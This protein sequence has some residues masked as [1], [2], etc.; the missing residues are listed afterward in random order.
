M[1]Y[2]GLKVGLRKLR[3]AVKILQMVEPRW[4]LS[5]LSITCRFMSQAKDPPLTAER[6]GVS[7][8]P[9]SEISDEDIRHFQKIIPGRVVTHEGDLKAHNID[10]L[11]TVRGRSKVLLKPRTTE[12]VSQILK[13]CNQR[14]LAVTPQGGN[15]S[16]VGGSIPVF[17]E[18]LIST[19]LM[20]QVISFDDISGALVC[21]AGC[22][23]ESLNQYL[24]ERG[25][26][27]PLDLGAK[28]SCH[29]GGNLATNAGGLR[30]LRYGS[31]RG[32]VLGLEAVL[33]DGSILDCLNSLRKDNTGYDLKQLFI[34]SEGTLGLI[35]ALSIL[36]PRKPSAVNVAL[37]GCEHFSR[38]L[39]V[40]TLCRDHLGEIL[41]ACEF[42]DS[43]SMR[44]VKT[45]LKLTNPLPDNAFYV[46]VE[47][48]GSCGKHDEEKLN[49]FLEKAMESGLVTSGTVATDQAKIMSLWALRER[50][51]EALAHDG[52]VYKYDL[53]MP[54]EKLYTLVE[55]TRARVGSSAQCVVGYGHLGDGN[56]HLNITAKSYSDALA[57]ALEPFVY[58]WTSQHRGSISAEHGLG[59][60]KRDHIYYSKSRGAVSIMQNLKHMLDPKGIMNPYKTIPPAERTPGI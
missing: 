45:H 3:D 38:V 8:L 54:V 52:Y 39:Q 19:A 58:E 10:W 56:L 36:C 34:G 37:L 55:E 4:G 18:I 60:K 13:Y 30:L 14:D 41:S 31:L 35:T 7:R 33:P 47:T 9:F 40:F 50:I 46:L 51:T 57:S 12:E 21:Q 25:Y 53:S 2:F 49:I 20:D 6:Y 48:S 23:L 43:E 5:P 1:S 42:M 32:T 11:R 59:F 29:I 24:G 26:T 17:D 16:L 27:M 28:G 22:I 44:M 15:T